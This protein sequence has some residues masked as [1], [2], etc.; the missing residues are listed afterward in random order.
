MGW[1]GGSM[2]GFHGAT[3][4]ACL[5]AKSSCCGDVLEVFRLEAHAKKTAPDV[6]R[7]PP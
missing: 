3:T 4:T 6:V 5:R 7:S 2:P 1:T